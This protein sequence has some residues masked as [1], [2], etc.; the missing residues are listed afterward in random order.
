[1]SAARGSIRGLE[2]LNF[3]MANVQTGFGPFISAY[4]TSYAWPQG[5][6]GLVLTISGIISLIGQLPAGIVVDAMRSKR[7]AAAI[8]IIAIA[9]CALALAAWPIFPMVLL[10][11]VLHGIAS[12]LI[13][14][15]IAAMTIGLVQRRFLS[16]QFGRNASFASVGAGLA[17]AAMGACGRLLSYQAVFIFT[18]ILTLPALAALYFIHERDIHPHHA[19]GSSTQ[20]EE[21]SVTSLTDILLRNR[22][23]L[24][25]AGCFLLF[26]LANAAMLPLV[27]S[28]VTMH[29]KERAATLI[30]ALIVV[31][32]IVVALTSPWI[33]RKSEQWGR[34]PLLLLGFAVLPIRGVLFSVVGSP[35]LLVATQLLDGISAAVI[36]V[37]LPIMVAD[38]TRRS[39]H[40]NAALGAVGTAAGIGA[41]LS[42]T[43]GG[44]A[45]DWLGGPIAFLVL[46]GIAA[47]GALAI[48]V[49]MPETRPADQ[50]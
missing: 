11:E 2:W 18:A 14:P 40:F 25:L 17:A 29:A 6:I 21:P 42:T 3:F 41:S 28:F 45:S 5:N 15:A 20:D 33:G 26:H 44:Y 27:A 1:M 37:L 9:G 49:A 47:L 32:Q 10:A 34:K 39:G 23:L 7:L 50:T 22:S 35:Y 46:A 43:I 19:R 24:I 48:L 38:V 4:L 36:G 30:A 31:P 12:C 16:K 13:G 8:A